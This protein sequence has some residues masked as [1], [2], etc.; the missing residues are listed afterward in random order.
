MAGCRA[1]CLREGSMAKS[2]LFLIALALLP[3]SSHSE[4][5]TLLDFSAS[6]DIANGW[7]QTKTLRL[8]ESG[9][10]VAQEARAHEMVSMIQANELN[11]VGGHF[12]HQWSDI[13]RNNE[14]LQAPVAVLGT[15]VG[16]WIGRDLVLAKGEDMF[17]RS[18]VEGRARNGSLEWGTSALTSKLDFQSGQGLTVNL[19]RNLEMIQSS[20]NLYYKFQGQ[21]IGTGLSHEL[22]RNVVLS[23][24]ANQ[25]QLASMEADARVSYSL[26]F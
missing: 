23:V 21:T 6:K 19:S 2:F 22:A 4:T 18:H 10:R 15:T 25:P 24:N 12:A 9:D 5:L 17:L 26:I 20:A 11:H 1:F 7:E 14:E 16:F 8:L 13:L 3:V